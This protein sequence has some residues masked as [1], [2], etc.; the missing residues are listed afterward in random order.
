M[1]GVDHLP[2]SDDAKF[3]HIPYDERWDY[4]RPVIV[5]LFLGEDASDKPMTIP[6]LAQFM[7][8][9]YSFSAE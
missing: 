9:H 2:L 3:L 1:E 6:R 4:L 8:N 5:R 7:T